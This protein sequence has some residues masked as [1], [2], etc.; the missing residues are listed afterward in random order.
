[1]SYV[2]ITRMLVVFIVAVV[3]AWDVYVIYQG[4]QEA[5]FSVVL[6]ESS[7]RWPVI[8]FVLGFLCG[9]VFWQIYG[10]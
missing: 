3:A 10:D 9:H 4:Q 1:M 7:R 5:T 8:A 6:Y 2:H